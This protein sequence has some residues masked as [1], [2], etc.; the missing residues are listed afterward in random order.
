MN[1]SKSIEPRSFSIHIF[2][3]TFACLMAVSAVGL[4]ASNQGNL[5]GLNNNAQMELE[6]LLVI[7]FYM[8]FSGFVI[9]VIYQMLTWVKQLLCNRS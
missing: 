8:G 1:K 2:A 6:G 4:D 3:I 5:F 9:N 7:F